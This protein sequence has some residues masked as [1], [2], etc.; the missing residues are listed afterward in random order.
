MAIFCNL[1]ACLSADR[2]G[3]DFNPQNMWVYS[4]WLKFS[5]SLTLQKISHFQAVQ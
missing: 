3:E 1:C 2:S 4:K 5:P